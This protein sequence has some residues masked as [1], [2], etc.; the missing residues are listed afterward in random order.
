MAWPPQRQSAQLRARAAYGSGTV[1][2]V[3]S[4]TPGG[5]IAHEATDLLIRKGE[6]G[7]IG[8]GSVDQRPK[9]SRAPDHAFAHV[10]LRPG[11]G[12]G[13]SYPHHPLRPPLPHTTGSY[14]CSTA[15]ARRHDA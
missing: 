12:D 11:S 13:A 1:V 8:P 5:L 3:V 10:G 9:F 14:Q 4:L 6:D 15:P 2:V 7:G